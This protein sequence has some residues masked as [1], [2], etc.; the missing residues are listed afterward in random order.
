MEV[1]WLL[2]RGPVKKISFCLRASLG[3]AAL[4]A[5][6]TSQLHEPGTFW[7]GKL[8]CSTKDRAARASFHALHGHGDRLLS[9]K[10]VWKTYTNIILRKTFEWGYYLFIEV[11]LRVSGQVQGTKCQN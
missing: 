6:K 4:I 5:R 3:D 1:G 11:E 7:L 8:N 2:E 9:R 10:Q